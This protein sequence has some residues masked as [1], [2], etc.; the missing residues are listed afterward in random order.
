MWTVRVLFSLHYPEGTQAVMAFRCASSAKGNENYYDE[1]PAIV[2]LTREGATLKLIPLAKYENG[3]STLFQ[4]RFSQA[5]RAVGAQLVELNVYHSSDN[6]CCDG[7]DEESGNRLMTLDL[8]TGKLV[9]AIDQSTESDSH[10]D[11]VE[12]GDTHTDCVAKISYLRDRTGNVG[13]IGTET[14]CTEN[15][16]PLPEVKRHTYSWN[17]EAHS[18]DEAK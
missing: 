5:F 12:D 3:D 17:A 15:Q 2:S 6:P 16:K 10:D 1:R 18:F 11:S 7:G 14:R 4:L 8:S 13:S 9:L